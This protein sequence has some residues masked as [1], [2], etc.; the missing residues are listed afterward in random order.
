MVNTSVIKRNIHSFYLNF[1]E[2]VN[3]C[4]CYHLIHIEGK[5]V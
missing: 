1:S 3:W 4:F 5:G 2:D